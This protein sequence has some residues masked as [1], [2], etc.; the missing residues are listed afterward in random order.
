MRKFSDFS[1]ERKKNAGQIF[2]KFA[3]H[4]YDSVINYLTATVTAR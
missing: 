2:V 1:R 4:L 3:P